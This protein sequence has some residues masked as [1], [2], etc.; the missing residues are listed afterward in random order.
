[1]YRSD[2]E[3]P[4]WGGLKTGLAVAVSVFWILPP[5]AEEGVQ[6]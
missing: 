1:M 6:L 3:K 2:M 4:R 5:R